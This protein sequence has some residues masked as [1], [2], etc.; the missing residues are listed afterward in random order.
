MLPKGMPNLWN[1]D[2]QFGVKDEETEA[3]D[4]A[5]A[6]DHLLDLAKISG[7]ARKRQGFAI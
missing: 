4:A 2:D 7:F 6:V 5:A 1:A 3:G